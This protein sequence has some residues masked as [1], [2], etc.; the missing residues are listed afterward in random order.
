MQLLPF[1]FEDAVSDILDDPK[2]A[3]DLAEAIRV[4]AIRLEDAIAKWAPVMLRSRDL[5]RPL[6]TYAQMSLLLTY[7]ANDLD[8]AEESPAAR[9]HFWSNLRVYLLLFAGFDNLRR[10]ALGERL[11]FG[12]TADDRDRAWGLP[13]P[14]NHGR[15]PDTASSG[16]TD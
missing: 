8:A 1:G 12:P 14:R 7:A 5:A 6:N 11:L 16:A 2:R 3:G 9:W 10:Q 13:L 15:W 4:L